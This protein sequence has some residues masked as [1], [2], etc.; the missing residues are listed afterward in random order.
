M[1]ALLFALLVRARCALNPTAVGRRRC[2]SA[3]EQRCRSAQEAEVYVNARDG[4]FIDDA[5]AC[6]DACRRV[7]LLVSGPARLDSA[8]R[9][10]ALCSVAP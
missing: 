5:S 2:G 1:N 6:T 8:L 4:S 3:A 10:S 7:L 9:R